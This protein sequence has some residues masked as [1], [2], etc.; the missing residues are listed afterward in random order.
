MAFGENGIELA[1][2]VWVTSPEQGVN[3]VRSEINLAIWRAFRVHG[4]TIPLPQREVRLPGAGRGGEADGAA[5]HAGP[6]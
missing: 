3:N 2:R 6:G 4:I 1:L 5:G